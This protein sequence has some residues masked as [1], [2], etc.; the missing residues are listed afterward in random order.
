MWDVS[1]SPPRRRGSLSAVCSSSSSGKCLYAGQM[2]IWEIVVYLEEMLYVL[3]Y[4][5]E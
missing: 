3:L 1:S 5:I 4:S 2:D